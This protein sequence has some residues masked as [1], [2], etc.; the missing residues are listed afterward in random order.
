MIDGIQAIG[1]LDAPLAE[2]GAD[3]VACG[4]H[5]AMLGL[6]GTG[7][8]YVRDEM[9]D[10]L[11]PLFGGFERRPREQTQETALGFPPDAKRY[12]AGNQNYLGI[13]VMQRAA[14]LL[15]G[16]GFGPIEG[17]LA[18][19]LAVATPRP[20]R[21]RAGIVALELA[22]DPE[23]IAARLR[24]ARVLANLRGRY[25]RVSAHFYNNTD[26]IDRLLEAL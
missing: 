3:V 10:R 15:A 21:E 25:L 20:W 26:D 7:F 6:N 24:A 1:V 19:G 9:L 5:K 2:I 22:G 14:E 11:R 23:A 8:L 18:R 16:I 17:A 13:W 4:A 12:E